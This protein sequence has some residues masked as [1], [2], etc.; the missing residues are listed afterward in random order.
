MATVLETVDV[1]GDGGVIKEI[2]KYG[3]GD[4][5]E[6]GRKI[7]AH[8]TGTLLDGS[9]FDS[10]RDRGDPFEFT[11]GQGQVIKA[12]DLSF[13]SMKV[14]EEAMITAKPEYAYGSRATGTIPANSTLKF[15]VELLSVG[16][17]DKESMNDGEKYDAALKLKDEGNDQFKNGSFSRALYKYE[18]ALGMVDDVAGALDEDDAALMEKVKDL[19]STCHLN[20]AMVQIKLE[21]WS[22]AVK[23]CSKV[24]ATDANN[25]KA[26]FRRGTARSNSGISNSHH[27]FMDLLV[28]HS[29][30]SY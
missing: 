23:H 30:V 24:L 28:Q 29:K 3:E 26:L 14:G 18:E 7:K 5:P 13:A 22:D 8:Y 19:V 2:Y 20:A 12:W 11:L 1:S 27:S 16:P 4:L 6:S 15:H 9:K 25:V 21:K 10:S 17:K